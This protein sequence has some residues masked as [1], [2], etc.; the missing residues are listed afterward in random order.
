MI[1]LEEELRKLLNQENREEDSNTPDF[2]LARFM[3]ACLDAFEL[4]NNE[5]EV[6]YDVELSPKDRKTEG[7]S[8]GDGD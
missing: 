8:D 5:R 7:E 2:I 4:A 6:W 1:K 3:I